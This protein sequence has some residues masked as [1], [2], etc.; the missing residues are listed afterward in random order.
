MHI[1]AWRIRDDHLVFELLLAASQDSLEL[2]AP[3][4]G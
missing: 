2:P 4:L 1:L 3:H